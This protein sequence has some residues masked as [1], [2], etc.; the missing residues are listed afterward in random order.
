MHRKTKQRIW[1]LV[2]AA[3]IILFGV[4]MMITVPEAQTAEEVQELEDLR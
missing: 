4:F 2:I 3:V 1:A